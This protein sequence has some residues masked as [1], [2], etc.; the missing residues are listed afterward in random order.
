MTPISLNKKS[1][2]DLR[3]S[4]SDK[5]IPAAFA[6]S[7]QKGF[8]KISFRAKIRHA[9]QAF[10]QDRLLSRAKN[11]LWGVMIPTECRMGAGCCDPH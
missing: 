3:N 8:I 2:L 7:I 6:G 9:F 5:C 10:S 4:L 1:A 11:Q